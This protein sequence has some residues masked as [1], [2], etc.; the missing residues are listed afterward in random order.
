MNNFILSYYNCFKQ[1]DNNVVGVN[2]YTK[3]L[4]SITIE[5]YNLLLLYE[6]NLLE[7]QENYPAFFNLM[8]KLGVIQ[9][10]ETDNNLKNLLLFEN[11]KICYGSSFYHLTINPTLNCNFNCWYC[12]EDHSKK[13]ISKLTISSIK[14]YAQNILS[15]KKI[16]NF[17]LNWFGGEPLLEFKNV[18]QPISHEIKFL[19]EKYNI[20]F[21]SLITTNGYLIN[22]DMIPFFKDTNMQTFLITIDSKKEIHDQTRFLKNSKGTYDKIVNNIILLAENLSPQ[23]LTLRIN[24]IKENFNSVTDIIESFNPKIRKIININVRQIIQDYL[25]NPVSI[26]EI[27]QTQSEFKNAGFTVKEEFLHYKEGYK[28]FVDIHNQ[29]VINYDGRV[30]KCPSQ[31]F[32]KIKEDG[33]LTKDGNIIWHENSLP[34]RMAKAS[35]ENNKCMECK[36]L[37]VCFGL[38][39]QKISSIKCEEDYNKYFSYCND[40]ENYIDFIM[41]EF[42]KSGRGLTHISKYR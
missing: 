28:C 19:C 42:Q 22:E 17:Y 4:F 32:E 18:M 14:K 27:E 7:L 31:N 39:S 23:S 9:Y 11:R 2:L 6:K 30:F 15:S 20:H 37:P 40:M 16:T 34:C 29:A 5:N 41:N 12:F 8:R 1:F 38:C 10:F 3:L 36:Y 13:R 21:E 24:F 33:V 25:K 26:K 35:F